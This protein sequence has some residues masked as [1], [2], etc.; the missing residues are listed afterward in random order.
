MTSSHSEGI[1]LV[2]KPKGRTSFSLISYLRRILNVKTI[3]HA[4]TLDPLATGVMV[5][6]VGK[7]YTRL[8]SKLLVQ[9]KEYFAEITL[10]KS[11]DSFDAEGTETFSSEK[12]PTFEE[13][14]T[15]L[16]KFQGE[17]LQIPPMFSAKK[18][19]GQKLCDLARK[20]KTIERQ[21]VKVFAETVLIDYT[22][23]K[24]LLKVNCSK[25]T[26]IRSIAHDLGCD[27]GSGAFLSCLQRTKSGS[28]YIEDCIDG[29]IIFNHD[30]TDAARLKVNAALKKCQSIQI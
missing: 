5:L 28:F 26:Y 27:L 16:K 22:Y 29:N 6:M 24:I 19:N 23:P 13:V 12:V 21:P 11:T 14:T 1:L 20:G 8:S 10:G 17:F 18:V 7:N 9:D 25:G 2:N 4:G 3:G 15:A 30:A